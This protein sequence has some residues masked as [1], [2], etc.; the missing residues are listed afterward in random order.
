MR[1]DR[2]KVVSVVRGIAEKVAK[3]RNYT[4]MVIEEDRQKG[5]WGE[6]LTR[7]L[8]KTYGECTEEITWYPEGTDKFGAY[9]PQVKFRFRF[10]S[11]VVSIMGDGVSFGSIEI[12]DYDS[13]T[14]EYNGNY[15]ISE[16]M[17]WKAEGQALLQELIDEWNSVDSG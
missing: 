10:S 1:A 9:D 14:K 15:K 7:Y 6:E 17:F 3:K 8:E 2:H 16:G 13:I 12:S 4:Q 11:P 5:I